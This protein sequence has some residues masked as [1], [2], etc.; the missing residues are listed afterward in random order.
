M[1]GVPFFLFSLFLLVCYTHVFSCTCTLLRIHSYIYMYMTTPKCLKTQSNTAEQKGKKHYYL[2]MY[3][4]VNMDERGQIS[5]AHSAMS[6]TYS[7]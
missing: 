5:R 1:G 3:N 7:M 2:Y 4:T 6:L